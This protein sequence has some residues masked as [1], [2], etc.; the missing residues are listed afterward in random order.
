MLV[1][2]ALLS[3]DP[4]PSQIAGTHFCVFM[5]LAGHAR[6]LDIQ[7]RSDF[8]KFGGSFIFLFLFLATPHGLQDLSFFPVCPLSHFSRV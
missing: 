3:L 6:W 8:R 7:G 2:R 5:V 1:C 4:V